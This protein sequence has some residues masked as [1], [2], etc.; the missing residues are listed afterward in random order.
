LP[1][2]PGDEDVEIGWQLTPAAWDHGYATET[3]FAL[4]SWAFDQGVDELFAV[5]RPENTQAAATVRQNGMHWVGE[6]AKYFGLELQVFRLR[7]A[8][9]DRAAPTGHHPPQYA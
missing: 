9:L 4:A 8:D 7:R 2:P 1:L 6:T 3:T 5:V